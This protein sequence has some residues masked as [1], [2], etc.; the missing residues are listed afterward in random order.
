MTEKWYSLLGLAARARQLISGEELVLKDVKRNKTK[1][2]LLSNDAS[3][4]TKKK[5]TDKCTFYKVPLRIIGTRE[6]LGRA[7][8]KEERVVVGVIDAGFAKKLMTL[9]EQ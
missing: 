6:E 4:G 5:V 7:I 9:I 2:V 3:E 8:G 1:L